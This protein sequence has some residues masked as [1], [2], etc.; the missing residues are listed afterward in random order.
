MLVRP[1]N[2]HLHLDSGNLWG[3]NNFGLERVIILT[4]IIHR[5]VLR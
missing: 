3:F 1:R 4:L 5:R 2:L